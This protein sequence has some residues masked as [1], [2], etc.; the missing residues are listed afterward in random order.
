MRR[1]FSVQVC[2]VLLAIGILAFMATDLHAVGKKKG[3]LKQTFQ[4]SLVRCKAVTP[5]LSFCGADPLGSGKVEI[6]KDGD[7]KVEVRGAKSEAAYDVDFRP[8][9][10]APD[11]T[12]G[13]LSTDENGNGEFEEDPGFLPGTTLSGTMVLRRS[14]ADQFVSGITVGE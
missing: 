10:S 14:A 8:L 6:K 11:I 2:C 3:K 5:S 12:L 13:T 1:I 4:E 9:E 7:V